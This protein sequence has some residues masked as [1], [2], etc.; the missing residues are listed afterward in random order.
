MTKLKKFD[1]EFQWGL[2]SSFKKT[3]DFS[4]RAPRMEFWSF[5]VFT[6]VIGMVTQRFL[7]PHF[8][9][10]NEWEPITNLSSLIL[11]VPS[12]SVAVRRL[13][14]V[15]KSGWWLL[16]ALTVIGIPY[17]IYLYCLKGTLDPNKYGDPVIFED[18]EKDINLTKKEAL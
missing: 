18:S 17:L 14:D 2:I 3:F 11:L 7:D 5:T 12:I 13:H 1:A 10:A 9:P 16:I 8:F 15:N 4:S 6:I